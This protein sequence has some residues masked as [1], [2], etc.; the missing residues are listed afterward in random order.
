MWH[1][2]ISVSFTKYNS[3]D[4]INTEMSRACGMDVVLYS[5]SNTRVIKLRRQMGKACGMYGSE[6]RC[7]EGFGVDARGKETT[8]RIQA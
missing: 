3:G 1:V 4:Q 7:I 5:V 2:C 6:E 8:W